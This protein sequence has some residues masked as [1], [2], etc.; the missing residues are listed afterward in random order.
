MLI[1]SKIYT[2]QKYS[3]FL[4]LIYDIWTHTRK[5]E[6]CNKKMNERHDI[7]II[8]IFRLKSKRWID[9]IN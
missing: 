7:C 8:G 2:L 9:Q 3:I 5:K 6:T 1:S 4:Q